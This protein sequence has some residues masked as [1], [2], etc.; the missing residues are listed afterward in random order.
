MKNKKTYI[1]IFAPIFVVFSMAF[2]TQNFAIA[3]EKQIDLEAGM[4]YSLESSRVDRVEVLEKFFEKYNSPLAGSAATFITVADK[5]DMD[6][7]LLPAISCLESGCGRVLIPDTYNAWGW[8]IY[9]DNYISFESW[10]NGIEEVGKG[11][12]KGYVLKG[13]DTPAKMAP[14]YTPPRPQHWLNGVSHFMSQMDDVS[15]ELA[16]T[17][18]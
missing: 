15:N 7:R 2:F 4:S 3:K 16:D 1:S 10:D 5:Y 9:G 13:L 11:I 18:V 8:G 17:S 12:Y 6:Y 14:V